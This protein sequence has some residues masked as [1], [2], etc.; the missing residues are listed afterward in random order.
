MGALGDGAEVGIDLVEV[1][2]RGA[3][4]GAL[5]E[6]FDHALGQVAPV[7]RAG[8]GVAEFA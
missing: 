4:A 2:G 7:A 1:V 3:F 8:G 5:V 6:V